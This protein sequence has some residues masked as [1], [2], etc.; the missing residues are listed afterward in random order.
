[1]HESF[2]STILNVIMLSFRGAF[3]TGVNTTLGTKQIG[4][5]LFFSQKSSSCHDVI[6]QDH[7]PPTRYNKSMFLG[8]SQ[9]YN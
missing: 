8:L 1:M 5:E 9:V 6:F 2:Q 4:L 7:F 3:G